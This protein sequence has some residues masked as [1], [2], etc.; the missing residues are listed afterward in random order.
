MIKRKETIMPRKVQKT[1]SDDLQNIRQD[2]DSLRTNVV[3]LTRHLKK[4]GVQNANRL[5]DSITDSLNDKYESLLSQGRETVDTIKTQTRDQYDNF[6]TE[7]K[8]H[9]ARSVAIAFGAGVL[10]SFL[11]SKTGRR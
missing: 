5:T 4:G 2:L 8:T 1:S 10:A 3:E 9:P 6:E 11:A 7:V